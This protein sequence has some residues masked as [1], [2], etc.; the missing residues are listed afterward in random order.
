MID[1]DLQAEILSQKIKHYLITTMGRT[2]DEANA[3]QFFQA[4][5]YA[6]REEVMIHWSATQK[7]FAKHDVRRLFFLSMEYLP[8]KLLSSNLTNLHAQELVKRVLLKMGHTLQELAAFEPD[9]GLG[10]GGLGRLASCF[11]D[12]LA[13]LE[14][15]AMAY[16]LRYQYGIFEQQLWSGVQIEKPDLWLLNENPW[17]FRRDLHAQTVKFAGYVKS[18]QNVHGDLADQLYDYEEVRALPFDIPIVGYASGKNF[19]VIAL[20]LWSTKESPHNFQLQR[21]NAGQIG[22]AAENTGLTD[23]LYPNDN[24][25]TGKRIRLKQ[26]FL[27]VSASI[28]DIFRRYFKIHR[29]LAQFTDKIRIQIND[30]HPALAIV[31]LIRI[32]MKN[33]IVWSKALEM[34]QEVCSYTNHTIMREALE[35]WHQNQMQSLLPR[36]CAIIERLN[37]DFCNQIRQK[38]NS[39]EEIVRRMS[40]I[41]GGHIKMAHLAIYGS[42][43]VNGVAELH[44]NILKETVFKDFDQMFPERFI[45][46]TNGVTHRQWLLHC[47]PELAHF[48]SERIGKDWICDFRQIRKLENFADDEQS[49]GKFLEI[50]KNNKLRLIKFIN[51]K[52]PF[53][54]FLGQQIQQP[55]LHLSDVDALF[56]VQIKRFHEYKRQ[57][58][59]VLNLIM[60]YHDLL[61][62]SQSHSIKRIAI[63]SGKAAAGYLM[64]KEIIR[65]IYC[66]GRKIN[67]DKRIDGKL[68]VIFIENYG[69]SKAEIIIP[70]ADLSEQISTAGYEASGTGN[71]KLAMNGALTIGTEDGANIEMRQS[72]HDLFWPFGFGLKSDEVAQLKFDSYNPWNIYSMHP[73]IKKALDALKDNT[74]AENQQEEQAFGLIFDSLMYGQDRYFV[75]KDLA[76]YYHTQLKAEQYYMNPL[77]WAATCI[78]NIAGM[79][80][81][82]TD[83]SIKNYA[84]KIWG[85]QPCP[86]DE[87]ILRSV[88]TEYGEHDKC[89]ILAF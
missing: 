7:T 60:I 3:V 37:Q 87:E 8:G 18:H 77:K 38:S 62:D 34:T 26:E 10:N 33:N 83:N 31:E 84:E 50:K 46:V 70:A 56:D 20:R 11:L 63:F 39:N 51:E 43:S 35:E 61:E 54:D 79:G 69:V 85:L 52:T 21:F 12:S 78:R 80:D 74:F 45:N 29:D 48:I 2:A 4:M 9:P 24:H 16:G 55:V 64:A 72:I 14:Y 75:I 30:T 19:P 36:Q 53:R 42:H 68:K 40:I 65:L 28:Q 57:L 49:N 41:E 47:N 82:S 6:L 59:N 76:D 88:K 66:L 81:F 22:S 58:M 13:T 25:E 89:R 23:V 32:F 5:S 44:T 86:V 67:N 15:P 73:K 1:I 71:M 27:L 17:E